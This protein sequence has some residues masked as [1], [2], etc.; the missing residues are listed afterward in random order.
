VYIISVLDNFKYNLAMKLLSKKAREHVQYTF[1]SNY[2]KP[3]WSLQDDKSYIQESYNRIAWVYACVAKISS[4]VSSVKWNLYRKQRNGKNIQ[5]EEHPLISMLNKVNNNMSGVDFFDLW[6]TYLALNGKFYALYNNPS[7]PTQMSYLYPFYIKPIPNEKDFVS[8]FEYGIDSNKKIYKKEEVLWD[9]FN[10]PLNAYDGMSPIRAMA[11]TIDTENDAICWNKNTFENNGIPPGVFSVENPTN[12]LRENLKE[13]WLSDY[14]GAKNARIPLIID[15]TKANYESFGMNQVDMDFLNQRKLNRIEICAGFEVPSQIVGDPEGQTYSNYKEALKSF[16]ENT[17][18]PKYLTKMGDT[19]NSD[20]VVR[21]ADNL[22]LKPDLDNVTAL[23]DSIDT[24]ADRATKLFESGLINQ[25][26]GREILKFGNN[27]YNEDGEKFHYELVKIKEDKE[28]EEEPEEPEEDKKSLDEISKKKLDLLCKLWEKKEQEK[29]PFFRLFENDMIKHFDNERKELTSKFENA[30]KVNELN[31]IAD[32]TINN[33]KSKLNELFKKNLKVTVNYFGKKEYKNLVNKLVK[34]FNYDDEV[35]QF[36]NDIVGED[37]QNISETTLTQV[38]QRI[39]FGIS[40][41][42][43]SL[44]IARLIDDLYTDGI[45]RNRSRTIAITEVNSAANYGS[46]RGASQAVADYDLNI[47]KF[48]M[49]TGDRRTR[50]T[51]KDMAMHEPIKM[52]Q[53][54]RV[55]SGKGL[56]PGDPQ[57]PGSERARCRCAIGY[58]RADG[59]VSYE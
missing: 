3:T 42:M 26:E 2:G 4:C 51:H 32:T 46:F 41:E 6:A 10:D 34:A 44:Q 24:L 28:D 57:L 11:R 31:R 47:L 50:P 20:L 40:Q 27:T 17:V 54:F 53:T 35:Q 43:G 58:Q 22:I 13:K 15:S 21:Y 18:I 1:K 37:I 14:A 29:E 36:V 23:N 55:G 30:K 8:G 19:L 25:N 12:E 5:I 49:S 48:W 52:D 45:T 7:L 56:F 16:W 59:G 9:K 33:N 38:R 39:S